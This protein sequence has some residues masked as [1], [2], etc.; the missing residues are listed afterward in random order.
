MHSTPA[1]N[2]AKIT[3]KLKRSLHKGLHILN[4]SP[5]TNQSSLHFLPKSENQYIHE[6]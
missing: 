5:L 4:N 2:N 3:V 6:L 1:D